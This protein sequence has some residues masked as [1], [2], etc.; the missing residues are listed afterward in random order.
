MP[1]NKVQWAEQW[2]CT[3]V[4]NLCTFLCRPLQNNMN[5][6]SS[7]YFGERERRW[8][9]LF[10]S[11]L[12]S[13]FQS[14]SKCETI[15]M[16]MTLI[17]MK[18]KL[19]AELIFIWKVSHL[20]SFWNRAATRNSEM[21]YWTLALHV[22]LEQALTLTATVVISQALYSTCRG[23]G[24]KKYVS[25]RQESNPWPPRPVKVKA[26]DNFDVLRSLQLNFVQSHRCCQSSWLT[27]RAGEH[28]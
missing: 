20:D 26:H 21:A 27:S 6:L 15:L 4:S 14:K 12:V 9:R 17:C 16:K 13:L 10:P 19:H 5:W 22:S 1:P 11:S 28:C 18:M 7:A 25:P 2:L 3:C 23:L 8:S 24:W